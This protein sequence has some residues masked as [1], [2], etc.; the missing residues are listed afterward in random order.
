MFLCSLAEYKINAMSCQNDCVVCVYVYA[1]AYV[2]VLFLA[3]QRP[4][5]ALCD[6]ICTIHKMPIEF[7]RQT[8]QVYIPIE[9]S[10]SDN[11]IMFLSIVGLDCYPAKSYRRYRLCNLL[12]PRYLGMEKRFVGFSNSGQFVIAM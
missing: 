4:C 2:C 1:D 12:I 3:E 9:S 8:V 5:K 7:C 10:L 6:V 11:K